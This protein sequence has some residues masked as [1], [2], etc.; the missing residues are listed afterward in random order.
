MAAA[1]ERLFEA[2]FL[3][4]AVHGVPTSGG[5]AAAEDV[6][7][8]DDCTLLAGAGTTKISDALMNS[9]FVATRLAASG[10]EEYVS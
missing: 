2:L 6:A 1:T 4:D 9:R 10:L 7:W 8:F 3:I 5:F